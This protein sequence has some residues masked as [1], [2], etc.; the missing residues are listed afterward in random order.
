M[1]GVFYDAPEDFIPSIN[2]LYPE[3][4]NILIIYLHCFDVS[5]HVIANSYLDRSES[6]NESNS[7]SD[8]DFQI[9]PSKKRKRNK[10]KNN[11][12]KAKIEISNDSVEAIDSGLELR[13]IIEEV[14]KLRMKH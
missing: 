5:I 12:K 9:S 1:T 8:N 7:N 11:G 14:H 2:G 4:Y 10:M 3:I 13:E 6:D